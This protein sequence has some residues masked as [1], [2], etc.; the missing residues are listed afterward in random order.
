MNDITILPLKLKGDTLFIKPQ[1][2]FIA[3]RLLVCMFLGLSVCMFLCMVLHFILFCKQY[4]E[5]QKA[6]IKHL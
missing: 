6:R 1:V 5:I 2:I 4:V 3:G